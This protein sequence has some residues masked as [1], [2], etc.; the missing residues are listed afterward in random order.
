M[1]VRR[2]KSLE[3]NIFRTRTINSRFAR[4]IV[5]SVWDV[6]GT[7]RIAGCIGSSAS[8]NAMSGAAFRVKIFSRA[9]YPTCAKS[10]F[11]PS[12]FMPRTFR[13]GFN[14]GI[15]HA[16]KCCLY[17]CFSMRPPLG[18]GV[19]THCATTISIIFFSQLRLFAIAL[20]MFAL[21]SSCF[22]RSFAIFSRTKSVRS[23]TWYS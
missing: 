17:A 9:A 19:G 20:L 14:S 13:K 8:V 12:V 2:C 5:L 10:A 4:K 18:V 3:S 21:A 23:F 15:V 7:F 22:L 11:L 1:A 6:T 16:R